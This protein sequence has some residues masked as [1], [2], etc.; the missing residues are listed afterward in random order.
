MDE[1]IEIKPNSTVSS[2]FSPSF[3]EFLQE[4]HIDPGVYDVFSKLPRYVRVLRYNRRSNEEISEIVLKISRDAGCKV[5]LVRGIPG[6]LEITDSAI[7]LSQLRSYS[8]GDIIGMDVS[9]GIAA[10]ALSVAPGDNVL[11]LCCAPGT[12][13]LLLAEMLNNPKCNTD[14]EPSIDSLKGSVTGVDISAHRAATCR[15]LIKKYA[16]NN[17]AYI[18]LFLEDGTTFD[19]K[20][21]QSQWWDP[22]RIKYAASTNGNLHNSWRKERK[23][24]GRPWFATKMLSTAYACDGSEL[25]DRVLVDA[26]CTHDGS[27]T[28]VQKYERWGWDQ[29][30]ALVINDNRSASVPLLQS[31]LLENGWRLLKP[32]GILVYSTCSLS[33]YQN[34]Y[35]VGGFLSRHGEDEASVER[36]PAIEDA[37]IATAPIWMPE[38]ESEQAQNNFSDRK[39][40]FERMVHAVRLDPSV[41]NSSGMFVARIRK[42]KGSNSSLFAG[43]SKSIVPLELSFSK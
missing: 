39:G 3:L 43:Q 6:F 2:N 35:V 23:A 10:L 33:R 22:Q 37:I 9:S 15:S 18:R 32:G 12:K 38:N 16:G 26:E 40:I 8:S 27:L 25:Y 30:D 31:R 29:L 21:P 17:K 19:E 34:E 11:D 42:L 5:N 20:A 13:L 36:I 28:H 1:Q 14:S 24:D 7:K 41:S 4:N